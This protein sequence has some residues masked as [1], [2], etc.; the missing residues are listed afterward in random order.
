MHKTSPKLIEVFA[1]WEGLPQPTLM[2]AL[3]ATPARGKEIF[4]SSY[5]F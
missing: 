1:D 2:G 3:N 5:K 4:T